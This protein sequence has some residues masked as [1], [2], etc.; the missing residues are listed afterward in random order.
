M[1]TDRTPGEGGEEE[2]ST[3][4]AARMTA[5]DVDRG[6]GLRDP[7]LS[8]EREGSEESGVNESDVKLQERNP[9]PSLAWVQPRVQRRVLA[10]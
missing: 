10:R 9:I 2:V 3:S 1:Q 7:Q 6:D 5:G 8:Q 4:A